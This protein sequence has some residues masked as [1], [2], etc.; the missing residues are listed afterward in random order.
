MR[1]IQPPSVRNATLVLPQVVD[2]CSQVRHLHFQ[3]SLRFVRTSTL[4]H[5][6]ANCG[7]RAGSRAR[8]RRTFARTRKQVQRQCLP[9]SPPHEQMWERFEVQ[10][11][12]RLIKFVAGK[13][14][15][16]ETCLASYLV[17]YHRWAP[18]TGIRSERLKSCSSPVLP[19]GPRAGGRGS[20][21]LGY[22]LDVSARVSWVRVADPLG[23]RNESLPRGFVFSTAS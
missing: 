13:E 8:I 6:A 11:F 20:V 5:R 23:E 17:N 18:S 2:F 12:P 21:V 9:D 3:V 19:P 14:K 7:M 22:Q 1:S 16:V 15:I 4:V 10:T